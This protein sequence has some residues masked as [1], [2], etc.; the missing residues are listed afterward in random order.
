MILEP[1]AGQY[2]GV[3]G[4][5]HNSIQIEVCAVMLESY[6]RYIAEAGYKAEVANCELDITKQLKDFDDL[7]A[8]QVDAIIMMAADSE[9]IL[10]ALETLRNRL[11]FSSLFQYRSSPYKALFP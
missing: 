9:K 10:P 11:S 1:S 2:K 6:K 3:I 7:I 4:I 5:A 8:K